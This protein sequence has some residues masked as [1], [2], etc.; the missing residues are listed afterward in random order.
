MLKQRKMFFLLNCFPNVSVK[1]WCVF[2]SSFTVVMIILIFTTDL[3]NRHYIHFNSTYIWDFEECSQESSRLIKLIRTEFIHSSNVSLNGLS[4][5]R[6][7]RKIKP[8]LQ[9]LK[10]FKKKRFGTYFELGA[11]RG[12]DEPTSETDFLSSQMEWRGLL[13]Q[14]H[15]DIYK[16]ILEF[17]NPKVHTAQVCISPTI[18]VKH[19]FFRTDVDTNNSTSMPVPCFPLYS[20]MRAYNTTYLDLLILNRVDAPMQV[21][22]TLPLSQV[23]IQVIGIV[24]HDVNSEEDLSATAA[25]VEDFC[26]A[27]EMVQLLEGRG[28]RRTF[29]CPMQVSYQICYYVCAKQAGYCPYKLRH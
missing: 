7:Q 24:N 23:R 14:P 28:Y 25:F 4:A 22:K 11:E 16:E 8:S 12:L 1:H 13:T 27:E 10:I 15:P 2:L 18:Y 17:A 19:A 3:K 5:K 9:L 6:F 20:L 26:C 29:S 21:I